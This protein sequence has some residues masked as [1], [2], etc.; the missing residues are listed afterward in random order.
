M[1]LAVQR[2]FIGIPVFVLFFVI[3]IIYFAFWIFGREKKVRIFM[4][5]QFAAANKIAR[6]LT[7][8]GSRERALECRLESVT[9]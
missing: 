1:S 7:C 4:D 2:T 3:L 6:L 8:A 5:R 9:I